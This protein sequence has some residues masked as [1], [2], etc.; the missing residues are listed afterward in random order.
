MAIKTKTDQET[1]QYKRYIPWIIS[2][3]IFTVIATLFIYNRQYLLNY[4]MNFRYNDHK[5]GDKIYANNSHVNEV[6]DDG[7]GYNIYL[8]QL[9]RPINENDVDTMDFDLYKER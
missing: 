2:L 4:Y 7:T 6:H 3:F 5:P 8:Y 9:V 1:D